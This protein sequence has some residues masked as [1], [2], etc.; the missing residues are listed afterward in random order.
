MVGDR[1]NDGNWRLG[2]RRTARAPLR[3]VSVMLG[4]LLSSSCPSKG[5]AVQTF[6]TVEESTYGKTT[7]QPLMGFGLSG[8]IHYFL[9][10]T[11]Q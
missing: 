4:M 7:I 2:P 5:E 3:L 8:Y 9:K 10:I 6:C 11:C 1:H